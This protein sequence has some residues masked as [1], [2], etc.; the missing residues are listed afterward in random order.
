MA[1]APGERRFS[2]RKKTVRRRND[3]RT[4]R[5]VVIRFLPLVLKLRASIPR[6]RG[7]DGVVRLRS[8]RFHDGQPSPRPPT[9]GPSPHDVQEQ[10]GLKILY[11]RRPEIRNVPCKDWIPPGALRCF[12]KSILSRLWWRWLSPLIPT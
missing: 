7:G 2:S 4:R 8:R 1:F 5:E 12:L 6:V 9:D 10:L 3:G 11:L